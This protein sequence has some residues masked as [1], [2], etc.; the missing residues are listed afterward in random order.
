MHDEGWGVQQPISLS[1]LFYLL[2]RLMECIVEMLSS[3]ISTYCFFMHYPGHVVHCYLLSLTSTLSVE[4]P[5]FHLVQ[6]RISSEISSFV[7]HWFVNHNH[8]LKK[9]NRYSSH[10]R[11]Q[12]YIIQ[13]ALDYNRSAYIQH[14]YSS[15]KVHNRRTESIARYICFEKNRYLAEKTRNRRG[16]W[17]FLNDGQIKPIAVQ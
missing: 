4:S 6:R 9:K 1:S 8:N 17:I 14:F 5:P 13:N 3:W 11:Q 10:F 2:I 15:I 12:T 16:M 7:A